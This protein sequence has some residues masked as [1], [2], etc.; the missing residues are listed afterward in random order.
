MGRPKLDNPRVHATV[1]LDQQTMYTI[2]KL[3]DKYNI[4][5][6]KAIDMIVNDYCRLVENIETLTKD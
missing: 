4:S 3:S 1:R 6:G 5:K 2:T